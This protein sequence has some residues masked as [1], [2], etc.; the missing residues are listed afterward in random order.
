MSRQNNKIGFT[1]FAVVLAGIPA[2]FLPAPDH[3]PFES[4]FPPRQK[5]SPSNTT[6]FSF[7]KL[8][9]CSSGDHLSSQYHEALCRIGARMF[10][11]AR[12]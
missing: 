2:L 6:S 11:Q 3:G 7:C 4:G 10:L 1:F 8:E 9:M 5:T 12:S